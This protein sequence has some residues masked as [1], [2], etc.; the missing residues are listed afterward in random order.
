MK[1]IVLLAFVVAVLAQMLPATELPKAPTGFIWQEV[2]ELKAAFLKPEGWFFKRESDKGTVAYFITKEDLNKTGQFDTGLTVNVFRLKQDSAVD[3]GKALIDRM[4][5][6]H[7]GIT[8][9][10][11]TGPFQEVSCEFKDTDTSGTI[12]MHAFTVANPKTN[13]LYLF[14]FE[15]PAASWDVAWKFGKQIMDTLAIDDNF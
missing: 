12:V 4:S 11:A 14:I 3:R 15:S 6:Q 8:L 7:H 1:K 2:P 10:R 13:T 9:S 5:A